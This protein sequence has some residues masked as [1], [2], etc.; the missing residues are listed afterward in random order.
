[1]T[2]Y[3]CDNWYNL[4]NND[5]N[6]MALK[7]RRLS[8]PKYI[9]RVGESVFLGYNPCQVVKSVTYDFEHNIIIVLF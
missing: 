8:D 5:E 4:N 2:M 1:M 7:H 9:P 3:L 6:T